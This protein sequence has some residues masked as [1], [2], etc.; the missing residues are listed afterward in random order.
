[1]ESVE[2]TIKANIAADFERLD[3]DTLAQ[4]FTQR[5][6]KV[7]FVT[8]ILSEDAASLISGKLG[9]CRA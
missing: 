7:L 6:W 2:F 8:N 1:M 4:V 5:Q 3:W 9:R